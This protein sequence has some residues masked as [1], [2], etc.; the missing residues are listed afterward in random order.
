MWCGRRKCWRCSIT[1]PVLM[2][3]DILL[4][5]DIALECQYMKWGTFK[6][7]MMDAL[8]YHLHPI[9]FR[10]N[11]PD[12]NGKKSAPSCFIETLPRDLDD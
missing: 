4:Y 12:G 3:S 10:S 2:A 1:Y 11:G 9:Q 7:L 6:S 5:Q 8:V